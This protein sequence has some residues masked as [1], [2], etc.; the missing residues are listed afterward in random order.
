M[1]RNEISVVEQNPGG[2]QR[3]VFRH[4]KVPHAGTAPAWHKSQSTLREREGVVRQITASDER[5]DAC[6]KCSLKCADRSQRSASPRQQV[7]ADKTGSRGR[8]PRVAFHH[9]IR[10]VRPRAYRGM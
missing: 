4:E 10:L 7:A 1:A 9:L 3:A 8:M 6:V 2:S 5:H